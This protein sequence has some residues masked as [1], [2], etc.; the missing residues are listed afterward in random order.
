[1]AKAAVA[2]MMALPKAE[3]LEKLMA[4]SQDC[5]ARQEDAAPI[6]ELIQLELNTPEV[7]PA[8]RPA[9]SATSVASLPPPPPKSKRRQLV[10]KRDELR[11]MLAKVD[12]ALGSNPPSAVDFAR[13]SRGQKLQIT[14]GM[15][16]GGGVAKGAASHSVKLVDV[17]EHIKERFRDEYDADPDGFRRMWSE[18]S[19]DFRRQWTEPE[20]S[21][22]P[23]PAPTPKGSRANASAQPPP[24]H[25][26]AAAAQKAREEE[27]DRLL[28]KS[29]GGKAK[30]SDARAA[31]SNFSF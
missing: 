13:M 3:R 24:L 26:P 20:R 12:G 30:V 1:M 22:P 23:T 17:P 16:A 14:D 18:Q 15:K 9:S 10:E 21:K 29:E 2:A 31:Q 7:E 5:I 8:S 28:R 11:A 4:M 27:I 25:Q 19:E 6:L